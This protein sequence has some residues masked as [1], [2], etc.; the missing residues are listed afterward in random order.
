VITVRI[1]FKIGVRIIVRIRKVF[2]VRVGLKHY[3][4]EFTKSSPRVNEKSL[5][6]DRS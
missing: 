3:Y 1:R 6:P 2:R 4:Q 5:W